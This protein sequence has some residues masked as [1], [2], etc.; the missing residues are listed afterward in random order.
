MDSTGKSAY[1]YAVVISGEGS[2]C[3]LNDV[4][5]TG[6]QGAFSVSKGSKGVLNRC[7]FST[8]DPEG[9]PGKAFYAVY[10]AQ[11]ADVTINSG[12]YYSP[13]VAVYSGNND[14]PGDTFGAMRLYGGMYSAK[15]SWSQQQQADYPLPSGYAWSATGDERYPWTIVKE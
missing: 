9:M 1:A 4:T 11:G 6:I 15:P 7:D 3:E 12:N 14:I 5:M 2:V 13:R 10:T 8:A